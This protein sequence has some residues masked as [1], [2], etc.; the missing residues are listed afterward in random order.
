MGAGQSLGDDAAALY[1]AAR[2]GDTAEV[3]RL[4]QL[5][6]GLEWRDGKG[7]TPLLAAV[8]LN[9]HAVV[10]QARA[11]RSSAAAQP[12]TCTQLRRTMLARCVGARR[13]Q[14]CKPWAPSPRL[15]PS[16]P[17]T[18]CFAATGA[19]RRAPRRGRLARGWQRASSRRLL[20]RPRV[21]RASPCGARFALPQS[22][23]RHAARRRRISR[24]RG[25][26]PPLRG[27]GPLR[28]ARV[29]EDAAGA[30]RLRAGP[31]ALG[32]AVRD[33]GAALQRYAGAVAGRAVRAAAKGV[34]A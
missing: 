2:R 14:A 28:S 15:G 24:R 22:P 1:E 27:A 17:L 29:R 3:A 21:G 32:A 9:K 10:K 16:L 34:E 23:R 7:R 20:W 12:R 11:T 18:R 30:H 25:A 19:G 8:A 4:A 6:T 13:L 31:R 33:G 5:G 26:L